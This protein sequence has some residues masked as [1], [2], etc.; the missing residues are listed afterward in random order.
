[1]PVITLELAKMSKDKKA[2]LVEK[3]TK[4]VAE[5]SGIPE[6]AF[7]VFIKENAPENVGVGGQLLLDVKK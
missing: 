3:V 1:M 4:T 7:Y 5:I 6:Q 2:E